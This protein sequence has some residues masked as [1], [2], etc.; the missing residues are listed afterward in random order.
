MIL[1]RGKV[2]YFVGEVR[3]S[4]RRERHIPGILSDVEATERTL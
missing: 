2:E 3:M 1:G 4:A